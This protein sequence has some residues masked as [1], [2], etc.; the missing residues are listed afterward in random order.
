MCRTSLLVRALARLLTQAA[1]LSYAA[2]ALVVGTFVV[3]SC[4]R[5]V[6][7]AWLACTCC[8]CAWP[9]RMHS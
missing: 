6:C 3:R 2:A 5:Q 4:S 7:T 8:S 1:L 9:S